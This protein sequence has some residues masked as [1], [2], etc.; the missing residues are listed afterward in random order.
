MTLL[1]IAIFRDTHCMGTRVHINTGRDYYLSDWRNI[2][3]EM[4]SDRRKTVDW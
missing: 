1:Q 4:N 3:L 2:L